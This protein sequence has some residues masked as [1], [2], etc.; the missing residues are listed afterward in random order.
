MPAFRTD[1]AVERRRADSDTPGVTYTKTE[2][3]GYTRELLTVTSEEGARE[4]KKGCGV[5]TTYSFSSLS[6]MPCDTRDALCDA[7]GTTLAETLLRVTGKELSTLSLLVVGLGNRRITADALG[8]ETAQAIHATAHIARTMPELFRGLDA[9]EISVLIPGVLAE[10]GMESSDLA[11]ALTR[12]HRFDAVIAFDALFARSLSRLG[13][14]IQISDAGIEP[15]GGIGNRRRALTQET[16]GIPVLSVGVPTVT[17]TETLLSDILESA[18]PALTAG[19]ELHLP[20]AYE[21]FL[22]TGDCGETV[23]SLSALLA[24][25]VNR[26]IGVIL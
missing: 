9:A 8:C 1:L 6:E 3:K 21:S 13:R 7:V 14:T 22:S 15:G 18:P 17:D 5:Y 25:A 20:P 24:E 16:L 26:H 11:A 12:A 19:L 23:A 2:E 4:I 10:S